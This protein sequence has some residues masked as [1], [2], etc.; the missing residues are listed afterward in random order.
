MSIHLA[1]PERLAL[2]AVAN[3]WAPP[4][5]V[6]YELWARRNIVFSPRESQFPGP[7]NSELFPYFAEVYRAL[8]PSDPCRIVTL[9]KSA[10]IGGTILANIFLLGSQDL[11]PGDMLYVHP[12]EDNA[13]RWSKLKLKAMLDGSPRLRAVF[14]E[15]S[16]DGGDSVLFKERADGR[17]SILISGANSPASLSQVS[18]RLQIQDD[19]AK[20]EKNNAGDPENQA[21]SRTRAFEFGKILKIS[22]PLVMPGCRITRN[23]EAGSQEYYHVPCPHCGVLQTLDI[24]N[25]LANLDE[26]H[27]EK[28][29]FFCIECGGSIQ[30]HHRPE[31][32]R[33]E[34]LG[35]RAKWIARHP[36]AMRQHRSFHIWSAYSRLQSF[37]LIA[38][39]WLSRRGDPEKE[40]VFYN[41]TAGKAY[42]VKGEAPP[43]EELR[44]RG[45]IGHR[46]GTIP[47]SG[48][49]VTVGVDVNGTVNTTWLNWQAV[50]WTRDGRRHVIDYARIEGSIDDPATHAKLDAVLHSKWR[51]DSGRDLGVDLLAIDGNYLTEEVWAWAKRHPVSKVIMVRGV[52]GDNK[53][54]IARVKKE[55]NNRT[56]KVLRYQSRF[57]NFA[58]WI[59]K[60]ALYKN[61]PKVDPLEMGFVSFPSG[62]GDEYFQ[63]LTAERRVERKD[64]SGFSSFTWVKED[65]QRNE[66]LDTMCQAEAAA[67]KFGVRDLPPAGWDRFERDRATP[68]ESGQLDLEDI[69]HGATAAPASAETT[70]ASS[71]AA[72]APPPNPAEGKPKPRRTLADL[73][74]LGRK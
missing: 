62:M 12:T 58:S 18:M 22:T 37:E 44:N 11:D 45:E 68:V 31:I 28:S 65:G 10:Q 14:P 53:P 13:R 46:R 15:K 50:A 3:V 32:L 1:N 70:A 7:Y 56:G 39:E 29:C 20:W 48:L 17:G 36:D 40:K 38:R 24:E 69:M 19:L 27:P 34:E 21:D 49:I 35:G 66:A 9:A 23:F 74:A 43:W 26:K 72:T 16:R 33:P 51:H 42:Q 73:A 64:R 4:P 71:G 2:Q 6:D 60:W 47:A 30:E 63:E 57:Y 8:A 54:L 67:I 52:D 61:L 5:V 55:H 59:L 41:D 25:F